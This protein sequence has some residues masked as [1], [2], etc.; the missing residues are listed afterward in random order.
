[1][2]IIDSVGMGLFLLAFAAVVIVTVVALVHEVI[3]EIRG[4]GQ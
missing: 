4:G 3:D 1:M 2:N